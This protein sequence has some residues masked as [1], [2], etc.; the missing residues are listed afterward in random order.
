MFWPFRRRTIKIPYETIAQMQPAQPQPDD[1]YTIGYGDQGTVVKIKNGNTVVTMFLTP[2]EV[3]RMIR[4]LKAS[5]NQ[6]PD[7]VESSPTNP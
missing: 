1:G 3:H 7:H 4:L 5:M 6:D 2:D